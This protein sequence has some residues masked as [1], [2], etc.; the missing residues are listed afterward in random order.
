MGFNSGEVIVVREYL[1]LE[2]FDLGKFLNNK[3]FYEFIYGVMGDVGRWSW[4]EYCGSR[5]VK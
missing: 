4:F 3:I 2:L 5:K 1:V